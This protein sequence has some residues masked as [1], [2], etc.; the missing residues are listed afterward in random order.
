MSNE[1]GERR[2]R[3]RT[4]SRFM[5][6]DKLMMKYCCY[7]TE[8]V[9]QFVFSFFPRLGFSVWPWLSWNFADIRLASN[10]EIYLLLPPKCRD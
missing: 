8:L 9:K 6:W 10:S 3:F 7:Q 5:T 2:S 4:F 1:A